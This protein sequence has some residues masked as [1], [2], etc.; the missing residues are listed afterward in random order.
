MSL[1]EIRPHLYAGPGETNVCSSGGWR[2]TLPPT[3]A[4]THACTIRYWPHGTVMHAR[5]QCHAGF[6]LRFG[7]DFFGCRQNM[8]LFSG[9]RHFSFQAD[10]LSSLSFGVIDAQKRNKVFLHCIWDRESHLQHSVKPMP[11]Y[12]TRQSFSSVS[13]NFKNQI[14]E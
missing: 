12:L 1:G 5:T 10:H 11:Q 14:L 4:H 6:L 2:D 8:S 7:S 13:V 9:L 3:H